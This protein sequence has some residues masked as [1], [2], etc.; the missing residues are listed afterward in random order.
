MAARW[1]MILGAAFFAMLT[2]TAFGQA[3]VRQPAQ[4]SNPQGQSLYLLLTPQMQKEL[5][6]IPEQREQLEKIRTTSQTRMTEGYKKLQDVPVEERQAKY[7]ELY[8]ELGDATEKE[9]RDVLLPMQIKRLRQIALQTKLQQVQW[10]SG[11]L[12]GDELVAELEITAEQKAKFAEKE[13]EVREEVQRKTQEFYKQ[14]QE[15]SRNKLLDVLTPEQR[16]KL[17]GLT[18]P[19][20]EW[21][22]EAPGQQAKK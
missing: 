20:Y 2:G 21:K 15:E 7:M 17:E 6:I 8:R 4:W 14:L 16:R 22:Y 9:V 10:G 19:K 3:V 13:K 18:G 12:L 1:R 5:E 11:A